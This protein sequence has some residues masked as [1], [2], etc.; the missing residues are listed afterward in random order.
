MIEEWGKIKVHLAREMILCLLVVIVQKELDVAVL[1][2]KFN[3]F[4]LP[5]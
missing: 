2:N 3:K 5:L 1:I 4:E